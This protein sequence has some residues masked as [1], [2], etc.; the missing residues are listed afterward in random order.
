MPPV[1][2]REGILEKLA[3][4]K[5]EIIQEG[6]MYLSYIWENVCTPKEKNIF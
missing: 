4:Q 6:N 2:D 5:E 3:A 1:L